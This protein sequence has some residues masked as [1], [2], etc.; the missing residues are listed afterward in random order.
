M[1]KTGG[2]LLVH[3][4]EQI[5]VKHTFGIPGVHNTEIYD[6]LSKSS[7]ITPILVTHEVGASFAADGVS[8]TSDSIGTCLIVPAAGVTHAASGIAEAFL[9]GIPM[10]VITGGIR[11][12]SGRAYQLHDLSQEAMTKG[13]VKGYFR[14]EAHKEIIPIIYEAYEKATSGEP[15]PVLIEIPGEL[16]MLQGDVD[17]IINY[18]PKKKEWV[19]DEADLNE[20]IQTLKNSKKPGIYLGWGAKEATDTLIELAEL[21]GAPVCTTLQGLSVFPANH[22]LHTGMGFGASAVAAAENAFSDC[23]CM[24]A[25]G[26]RFSELATGSYGIDDPSNLIHID[27]NKEVFNKNYKAKVCLEGDAQAAATKILEGLKQ[28]GYSIDSA[29]EG[30]KSKIKNDKLTFLGEWTKKESSKKVSPGF[31]FK[32]LRELMD[33]DAI[34]VTDDGYHTFLTEELL[35]IYKSK[36]FIS[37]SDFNSMGYCVPAAN[38]AKLSNP[39]KQV[40]G[41]VGDGAFLMTGMETLT[42][43]NNNLGIIHFVF[44]D[45]ELGQISLFQKI[46]LNRKT[47]TV[48]GDIKFK[49]MAEATGAEYIPLM[50]DGEIQDKIKEAFKIAKEGK[51]VIVD[52]NIDYSQKTKFSQGVV[53]TNLSRFPLREKVRVL[54]RALKRHTIG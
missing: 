15:G 18:T 49:G 1:K 21:L 23:D 50:N 12:D 41:I 40:I 2:S 22:P 5:G 30:L 39:N 36:H 4:L 27:I 35:P 3:A 42:A 14:P 7:I 32:G 48:L 43:A 10:L 38:G 16:Q 46:P 25:I 47:C 44:N 24:L 51:P 53:K 11:R 17:E 19:F 29:R 37:P 20:A 8:R 9:D 6:E 45:G 33:D 26:V 31:F 34:V 54:G 28:S 13:F 52:V